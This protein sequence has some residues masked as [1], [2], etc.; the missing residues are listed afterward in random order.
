MIELPAAVALV[1]VGYLAGRG[2]P[3]QTLEHKAWWKGIAGI[4]ESNHRTAWAVIWLILN[5]R[6]FL[7]TV[8]EVRKRRAT[9]VPKRDE[10]GSG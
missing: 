1:L 6:A 3:V 7:T 8:Q 4:G 10:E 5:P 9:G 2:R